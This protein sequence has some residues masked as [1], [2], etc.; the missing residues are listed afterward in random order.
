MKKFIVILLL[1]FAVIG[2]TSCDLFN[3][4]F[5]PYIGTWAM[6][7]S[8]TILGTEYTFKTTMVLDVDTWEM[9]YQGKIATNTYEN[10]VA[11][12]G[13]MV[14]ASDSIVTTATHYK[15]ADSGGVFPAAWTEIS[16]ADADDINMTGSVEVDGDTLTITD[17]NDDE[18]LVFTR[19][20]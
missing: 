10:I 19:V 8:E 3:G 2:M 16:S 20:E 9:I 13:T 6:E 4:L 11:Y 17:N 12:K 1:V 7:D 5:Y 18:V 15:N 14:V